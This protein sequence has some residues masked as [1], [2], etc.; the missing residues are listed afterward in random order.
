M[1]K[2]L[3]FLQLLRGFGPRDQKKRAPL[4]MFGILE[5]SACPAPSSWIQRTN[6]TVNHI[7]SFHIGF[8]VHI[9]V[10]LVYERPPVIRTCSGC[11]SRPPAQLGNI[12][13]GGWPSWGAPA[14]QT[15]RTWRLRR[16]QGSPK[17]GGGGRRPPPPHFGRG[18][19]RP[20]RPCWRR[21]RQVRGV[22]GAGAPQE[23][24]P[25]RIMLPSCAGAW[26]LPALP[27]DSSP[28]QKNDYPEH[29]GTGTVLGVFLVRPGQV[30]HK[31]R[32]E[33]LG[34]PTSARPNR[35]T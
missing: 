15:P 22:W 9:V 35:V 5:L 12:I 32:K 31:H 21:R 7:C 20:P 1:F 18:G 8:F 33:Q 25:P 23:G 16:Q 28:D 17:W 2:V 26:V 3:P 19:R 14:P 24:Q 11:C 13:L 30:L 4:G 6:A 10:F 27:H 34:C 29:F